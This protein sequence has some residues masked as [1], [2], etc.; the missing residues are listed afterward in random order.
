[1]IAKNKTLARII[2]ITVGEKRFKRFED[3]VAPVTWQTG[4]RESCQPEK[5]F[6][7]AV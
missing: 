3:R 1:M 7:R 6:K 5:R 2:A 4:S